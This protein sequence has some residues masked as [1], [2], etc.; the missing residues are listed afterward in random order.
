VPPTSSVRPSRVVVYGVTGS[1]KS[2]LAARIGERLGLPYHS[3]D[4]LTWSP[5]WVPVPPDVQRDRI[6]ALCA[7]DEWVIDSAYGIWRDVPLGRADLVV[8]LDF[9]R[10]LSLSRL[11]R[12]TTV[13]MVSRVEICNGNTESLRE[14]FSADSIVVWHFRSF[15]RKR[16]R[17]RRW[18]ADPAGPPILLFRSPAAVTRWLEAL[19]GR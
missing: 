15:R 11:I 17:M 9:P 3:I 10:W 6:T 18:H 8:G 13:R 12:R 14:I 1:G 19:P 16:Q 5:G 7:A 4:D 2:T